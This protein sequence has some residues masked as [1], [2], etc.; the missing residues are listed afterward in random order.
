MT[1]QRI[2]LKDIE[3][4]KLKEILQTVSTKKQVLT[5]QLPNGDEVIIQPKLPLK[6]LPALE[7]SVPEGWKEAIYK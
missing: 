5:I 2:K 1:S 6:P 3:K 7:G 4:K